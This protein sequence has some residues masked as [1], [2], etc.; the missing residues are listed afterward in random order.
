VALVHGRK[1][2]IKTGPKSQHTLPTL[3]TPV[4][5]TV[6]AQHLSCLNA[7]PF[8]PENENTFSTEKNENVTARLPFSVTKA[9]PKKGAGKNKTGS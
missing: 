7:K 8:L 6:F 3:Y 9:K 1:L 5:S 4:H 2:A